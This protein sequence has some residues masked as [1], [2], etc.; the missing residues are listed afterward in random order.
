MSFV[1]QRKNVLMFA[2]NVAKNRHLRKLARSQLNKILFVVIPK[3]WLNGLK[4]KLK[5][6]TM[7]SLAEGISMPVC[8]PEGSF[9]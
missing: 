5:P 6:L 7:S 3:V 1:S 2:C 4:V 8:V 9:R